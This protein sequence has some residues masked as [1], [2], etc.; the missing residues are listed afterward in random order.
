MNLSFSFFNLHHFIYKITVS[1]IAHNHQSQVNASQEEIG[2]DPWHTSEVLLMR[3]L[4]DE[5][6][7]T[8]SDGSFRKDTLFP[9]INC[10]EYQPGCY[11]FTSVRSIISPRRF[12]LT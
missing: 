10:K 7:E 2:K 1:S 8:K 9:T 6:P 3:L 5:I 11:K 12:V 4:K